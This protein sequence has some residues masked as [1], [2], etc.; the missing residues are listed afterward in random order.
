MSGTTENL[1]IFLDLFTYK[2]KENHGISGSTSYHDCV[3]LRDF[4]ELKKGEELKWLSMNIGF[5]GGR[6]SYE[7]LDLDFSS[8]YM[9]TPNP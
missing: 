5:L 7:D 8:T 4:G 9:E 6:T 2:S 3:M 1:G